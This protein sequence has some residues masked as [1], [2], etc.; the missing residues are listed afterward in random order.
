MR[1]GPFMKALVRTH[2]GLHLTADRPTPQPGIGEVL[3]E[4]TAFSISSRDFAAV[5]GRIVGG[6][7]AGKVVAVGEDVPAWRLGDVVIVDP[8]LGSDNA[9]RGPLGIDR[10]GGAA[11]FL[12]VSAFDACA[13]SPSLAGDT[14]PLLADFYS[15]AE[16]VLTWARLYRDESIIILG[17]EQGSGPAAVELAALRGAHVYVTA[18][19]WAHPALK[20]LGARQTESSLDELAIK[21]ANV[22]AD[23]RMACTSM[24]CLSSLVADGVY[25]SFKGEVART[26]GTS[27]SATASP[28]IFTLETL[29]HLARMAE[30]GAVVPKAAN[31]VDFSSLS[32]DLTGLFNAR[33]IGPTVVRIG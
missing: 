16:R 24:D 25:V 5:P 19:G 4:V 32:D 2:D 27:I 20:A 9:A 28:D 3:I 30:H 12:V 22:I 8:G 21:E 26:F 13:S 1:P 23:F 15:Q 7:V 11:E 18:Q 10:D 29:E 33:Q 31:V 14:L 17:A 6:G